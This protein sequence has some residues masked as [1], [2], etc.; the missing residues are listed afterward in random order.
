MKAICEQR[1]PS[2]W[3]DVAAD[4]AVAPSLFGIEP[5][6]LD[7]VIEHP[8]VLPLASEN[9]GMLFTSRCGFAKVWE[10]HTLYKPQGWGREVL[11]A[12]KQAFRRMFG[13]GAEMVF[14]HEQ[15]GNWRSRPPRS[16][17]FKPQG[18]PFESAL[19]TFRLWVLTRDAWGASPAC[20]RMESH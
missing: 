9:G 14:T 15:V 1:D 5:E 12:A 17:G 7:A 6:A 13:D 8:C 11:N 4:P 20:Q 3:R 2:F 19:G 18:A 10:L 16:F